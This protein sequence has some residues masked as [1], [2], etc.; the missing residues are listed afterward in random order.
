[1]CLKGAAMRFIKNLP[2]VDQTKEELYLH[3]GW[4]RVL[5][6][7][8]PIKNV[9]VSLV[10][11]VI[12]GTLTT[13]WLK[14]LGGFTLSEIGI[15]KNGIDI[16]ISILWILYY[17]ILVCVHEFLHLLFV[18][19]T[20]RSKCTY[21]GISWYGGFAYSAEQMTRERYIIISIMPCILLSFIMPAILSVFGILTTALKVMCV[22]NAMA[23]AMDFL[24]LTILMGQ[25][26]KGNLI[27]S[28][29]PNM[30]YTQIN[31]YNSRK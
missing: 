17:F 21:F 23:S 14:V 2:K 25:A 6:K 8:H 7:Q 9:V 13:L 3:D 24:S 18:P 16:K 20:F 30:Y 22:V 11:I 12:L 4:K 29:G 19:N 26:G 1:M 31:S 28:N 5:E 15:T 10:F 27:V